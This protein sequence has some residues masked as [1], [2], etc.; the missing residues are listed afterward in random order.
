MVNKHCCY[1]TCESDSRCKNKPHMRDVFSLTF[2]SQKDLGQ[3]YTL[4]LYVW[5]TFGAA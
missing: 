1:G 3:M 4:D 2:Q 5:K